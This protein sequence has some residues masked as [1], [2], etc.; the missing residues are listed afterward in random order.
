M[1][2]YACYVGGWMSLADEEEN[3]Y[4][5]RKILILFETTLQL[6]GYVESVGCAIRICMD[7]TII[8]G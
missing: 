7:S 4:N 6:R 8:R 1:A 2:R 5:F 3:K